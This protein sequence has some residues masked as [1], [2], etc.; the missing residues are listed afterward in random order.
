VGIELGSRAKFSTKSSIGQGPVTWHLPADL[1]RSR[2]P[3]ST[4]MPDPNPDRILAHFWRYAP[5]VS[6]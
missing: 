4:S 5:E 6:G 2:T 3:E 1:G